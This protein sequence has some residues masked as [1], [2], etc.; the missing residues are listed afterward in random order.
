MSSPEALVRHATQEDVPALR[1]LD[2]W[3]REDVW[4]RKVD[5]REVAV[6]ELGGRPIGLARYGLLWTT[7]PFLGL[8]FVEEAYRGRGYSRWLLD[9]LREH[10]IAQGYVALLS[11]SQTNE[12]APQ[13]WHAHVGFRSAGIIEHIA[14]DNVGELVYRLEL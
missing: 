14:D 9:F 4:R 11:S 8:I 7:V 12:P 2:P 5:A 10:L 3:P 1:A 13:A 6:L